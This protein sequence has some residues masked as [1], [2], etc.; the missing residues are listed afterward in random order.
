MQNRLTD[1]FDEDEHASCDSALTGDAG[2]D[3]K[4]SRLMER[5]PRRADIISSMRAREHYA[6]SMQGLSPYEKLEVQRERRRKRLYR[7]LA[8]YGQRRD[9]MKL[10]ALLGGVGVFDQ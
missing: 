8:E 4:V 5:I 6:P 2:K 1:F 9:R 3:R 10:R 7:R